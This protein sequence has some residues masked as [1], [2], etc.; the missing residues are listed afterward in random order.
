M[1]VHGGNSLSTLPARS[2]FTRPCGVTRR[3]GRFSTNLRSTAALFPPGTRCPHVGVDGHADTQVA[4]LLLRVRE[5]PAL[6]DHDDPHVWR[7]SWIPDAPESRRPP[8][9][10]GISDGMQD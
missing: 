5:A 9:M 2:R 3:S 8:S 10:W 4:Y 6:A 7:R 1:H